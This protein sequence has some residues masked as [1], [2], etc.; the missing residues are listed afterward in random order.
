M[1]LTVASR[2]C[3]GKQKYNSEMAA[4]AGAGRAS[5]IYPESK[6][7]SH[8]AY[9]CPICNKWHLTTTDKNSSQI[10]RLNWMSGK[11]LRNC[12]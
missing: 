12:T 9:P 1:D 11:N 7:Q 8:R 4:C 10:K 6:K 5:V 2:M 3:F